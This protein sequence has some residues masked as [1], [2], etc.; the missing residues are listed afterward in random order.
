ML[1]SDKFFSALSNESKPWARL[2]A[3]VGSTI[4]FSVCKISTYLSRVLQSLLIALRTRRGASPKG[5][6]GTRS[7]MAPCCLPR[8][9]SRLWRV[10]DQPV[11][12]SSYCLSRT[13]LYSSNYSFI[14]FSTVRCSSSLRHSL[15]FSFSIF[16]NSSTRF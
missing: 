11:F 10:V 14:F 6:K 12:S 2:Y 3:S 15:I 7:R 16:S 9:S 5:S 8:R 13:L 1:P 4:A